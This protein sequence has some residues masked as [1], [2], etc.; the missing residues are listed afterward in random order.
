MPNTPPHG[1]PKRSAFQR[2]I[3]GMRAAFEASSSEAGRKLDEMSG[4]KLLGNVVGQEGQSR[5]ADTQ[6]FTIVEAFQ[7]REDPLGTALGFALAA[8]V[9]DANERDDDRSAVASFERREAA[10]SLPD[11]L[12]WKRFA[13]D[14]ETGLGVAMPFL[15]VSSADVKP[16]LESVRKGE[17]ALSA[18]RDLPEW[19]TAASEVLDVLVGYADQQGRYTGEYTTSVEVARLLAAL[20]RP[21][22]GE[23]IFDPACG[24][25]H[26]LTACLNAT[27]GVSVGGSDVD[28]PSVFIASARVALAG[29]DPSGVTRADALAEAPVPDADAVVLDPP[30]GLRLSDSHDGVLGDTTNGDIAFLQAGLAR[31]K[32]GGRAA[33]V[34][35]TGLLS[36]PKAEAAR[37]AL[38]D[39]FAIDAVMSL[40][41]VPQGVNRAI[42]CV[43]RQDPHDDV[44]FVS[45]AIL[46]IQTLSDSDAV[47]ILAAGVASRRG[48]DELG[49]IQTWANRLVAK[50]DAEIDLDLWPSEPPDA[51]EEHSRPNPEPITEEQLA[52]WAR[53][54]KSEWETEKVQLAVATVVADALLPGGWYDETLH[55]RPAAGVSWREPVSWIADHEASLAVR[56]TGEREL[57]DFLERAQQIAPDSVSAP[58]LREVADVSRGTRI[59]S[60]DLTDDPRAAGPAYVRVGDVQHDGVRK[61]VRRLAAAPDSARRLQEG[62]VLLTLSGSV[63][64]AARVPEDLVGAVPSADLAVIRPGPEVQVDYLVALLWTVPYQKWLHGHATGVTIQHIRASEVEGLP[65]LLVN[66]ED[67]RELAVGLRHGDSA[68]RPLAII[69][70]REQNPFAAA[71]ATHVPLVE[72]GHYHGDDIQSVGRE[73]TDT[74]QEL[75][76]RTGALVPSYSL[77][78]ESGEEGDPVYNGRADDP[79]AEWLVSAQSA[80]SIASTI[81]DMYGGAERLVVM[82][83]VAD[84]LRRALDLLLSGLT[85]TDITL[86]EQGGPQFK[87]GLLFPPPVRAG[88]AAPL[89]GVGRQAADRAV[90]ALAFVERARD[91]YR[92]SLLAPFQSPF[93]VRIEPDSLELGR[94]TDV[95]VTVKNES[96]ASAH[97]V[98]VVCH[99]A[100]PG[101]GDRPFM[102]DD[103][104]R[105]TSEVF[106]HGF[107]PQDWEKDG[108]LHLPALTETGAH[109][110]DVDI[111]YV[112]LDGERYVDRVSVPVTVQGNREVSG[113]SNLG[114][115]PYVVGDPVSNPDLFFGRRG[116]LEKIYEQID[117]PNQTNLVLLE[118]TRRSGKSSVLAQ[119]ER[120]ADGRLGGWVVVNASLQEGKGDQSRQGLPTSEVFYRIARNV[121]IA[122]S[123]A[124]H[125]VELPGPDRNDR[126]F[127]TRV[128]K[129]LKPFF[130]DA[131]EDVADALRELLSGWLDELGDTRLLLL[132]DEFDKIDEGI[133]NGVTSP[134][135]PENL[136]ALFQQERRVSAVL[137]VFPRVTRMRQSYWSALFGLGVKVKV[138]P[139]E[140]DE[141]LSLVLDPV[142]GQLAYRGEAAPH[143][144][145]LCGRQ[146]FLVQTLADQVFTNRAAEGRRDVSV[147]VVELA[148]RVLADNSEHFSG[149]W[150]VVGS[151]R[152]QLLLALVHRLDGGPTP[153]TIGV[154]EGALESE[155][156]SLPDTE[157]L[158]R[159]HIA[160]LRE[161]GLVDMRGEESAATYHPTTLLMGRWIRLHV[162]P[163]DLRTRAQAEVSL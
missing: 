144:V 72:L 112:H 163:A 98:R 28:A 123:E 157:E 71:I 156:V 35:P 89:T 130:E 145:G 37:R 137:A 18:L 119:L 39:G 155:G 22:E 11:E 47:E 31:L 136:R 135:V 134:Q 111:T 162:D 70:N 17:R 140:P 27:P 147:D 113:E 91:S 67:Q 80:F 122:I 100:R 49:Y 68:A 79:F 1:S 158:G 55:V 93:T 124:G 38:L 150:D 40:S 6:A 127:R 153:V 141:A 84:R 54:N 110:L 5:G 83:V 148:A 61:P 58:P 21:R 152:R 99:P 51:G 78:W 132:L 46:S 95:L 96:P 13:S 15:G 117:R 36:L 143:L 41:D 25:G 103:D 45:D 52:R 97:D 118:G 60:E 69:G 108:V 73:L 139:L 62:D 160:A 20:I 81:E 74:L 4:R 26:L 101:D 14:P 146:P 12:R 44:W 3:D 109:S 151:A 66:E 92:A 115:S 19:R 116:A 56:L 120:D 125:T 161:L 154:L 87:D 64:R 65:I 131:G 90:A 149:L 24:R 32:P 9:L 138:G 126:L 34:V 29:G 42:L 10:T 30:L 121:A 159:D 7:A 75:A 133:Q 129:A 77:D 63:G 48:E 105:D 76:V 57:Q 106:D 102:M 107:L 88:S 142:R 16:S 85:E 86:R 114:A 43:S 53:Q 8:L 2:F 82:D 23:I 128:R 59:H 94:P 33:I 50:R 104:E